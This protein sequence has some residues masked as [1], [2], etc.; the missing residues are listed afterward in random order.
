[1]AAL[2]ALVSGEL[3]R[4]RAGWDA[5]FAVWEGQ[6]STRGAGQLPLAPQAVNGGS[7]KAAR[8]SLP[9]AWDSLWSFALLSPTCHSSSLA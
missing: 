2:P 6:E 3:V 7:R 4:L 5:V 1:M 9:A 8:A